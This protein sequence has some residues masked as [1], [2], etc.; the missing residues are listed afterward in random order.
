MA[1]SSYST[2]VIRSAASCTEAL[3]AVA[4]I[5]WLTSALLPVLGLASSA[6]LFLLP[7]LLAATR[8]GV[9]PGLIAAFAGAAAYN[10]FL[11]EPRLTFRVH[12]LDNFISVIVLGAVAVV[13]SRLATRLMKREAEANER[14]RASAE[15][16]ALSSLLASGPSEAALI[17]GVE[18]ISARY[19]QARLLDDAAITQADAGMSSLDLSAAAWALHNGDM[20]GH[21]TETMAAADWTFVPLAPKSRPDITIAAVARPMDGSIRAPGELD[22]V[23]QLCLLLG[24]CR[25]RANLDKERRERE[26]LE[27]TDRLRRTFLASLAHDFRTPLTVIAGRL[28]LLARQSPEAKDVLVAAQRLDRM[29]ADLVGAAR[30]EAGSLTVASESL[31]LVDVVSATCDG[32]TLP[33]GVELRRSIPA[34]LPFV[35]GDPVLLH[36]VIAIL[37][38]N[39]VR[40]ARTL[41]AVSARAQGERVVLSVEDDGPGVPEAERE[42]IFERFSRADGSDRAEGS[43]LGLAIVKG[44][45]DAMDMVVTI[46]GRAG[47]GAHFALSMPRAEGWRK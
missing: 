8:G 12:Q 15:A 37:S 21:G 33:P 18:F 42:R 7:V 10:Y 2:A 4:A 43:G 1:R 26:L 9:G 13:T 11:L 36:H 32:L 29:M 5:A 23:R 3:L 30:I 14:A 46:A 19:G 41:V 24:Q 6:L 28:D 35:A 47:G 16:A 25:D 38:D 27:E 17:K 20:T 31:D 22:Q 34:E 39:E 40:H 45:A 44:F